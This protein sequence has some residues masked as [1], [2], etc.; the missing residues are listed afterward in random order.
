MYAICNP[1]STFMYVSDPIQYILHSVKDNARVFFHTFIDEYMKLST[2]SLYLCIRSA[3][4]VGKYSNSNNNNNRSSSSFEINLCLFD[5]YVLVSCTCRF[6][7][8]C[9]FGL[10]GI[11]V[12]QSLIHTCNVII[13]AQ[14]LVLY[15]WNGAVV[16]TRFSADVWIHSSTLR[17]LSLR[18][19]IAVVAKNRQA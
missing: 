11:C 14:T 18:T 2:S 10:N 17:W 16:R 7:Y 15:T 3:L 4:F 9:A 19:E 6:V 13:H 1:C 5:L 8:V 12:T